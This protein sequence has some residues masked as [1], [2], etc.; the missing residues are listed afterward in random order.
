MRLTQR[1]VCTV[2]TVGVAR[3]SEVSET[4]SMAHPRW[5]V[6]HSE[7]EVTTAQA[8]P[9]WRSWIHAGDQHCKQT[10]GDW[11]D[12]GGSHRWQCIKTA[13]NGTVGGRESR[14]G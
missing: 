2:R 14:A 3:N 9:L 1:L 12:L 4:A 5:V 11:T 13:A 10:F 6:H 8:G 7:L